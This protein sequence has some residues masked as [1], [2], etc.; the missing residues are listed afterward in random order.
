MGAKVFLSCSFGGHE[1]E[2]RTFFVGLL[3]DVG[4]EVLWAI[5]EDDP[6]ILGKVFPKIEESDAVIGIFTRRHKIEGSDSW[7]SPSSVTYELAF[8]HRAGKG[9]YGFVEEGVHRDE[10]GLIKFLGL[11]FPT[12]DR[13]RLSKFAH[14]AKTYARS[15][16]ELKA[17]R[18]EMSYEYIRY[19][20]DVTV[21]HNGYGIARTR[22][23]LR[24]ISDELR[25][26]PHS[27]SLGG[28]ARKGTFL[29]DLKKLMKGSARLRWDGSPFLAF[30]LV[31]V[32]QEGITAEVAGRKRTSRKEIASTSILPS[33]LREA[34]PLRTNGPLVFQL[35]LRQ[36]HPIWRR[37]DVR[38]I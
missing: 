5:P 10:L 3:E 28:S 13:A 18:A 30:R 4:Y 6:T 7:T 2:V 17:V 20:K 15:W 1:E 26:I 27:F 31:E 24:C 32:P 36:G 19:V 12:F 35:C 22:C 8:A 23:T 29:P 21:Y 34:P 16:S 38:K 25:D 37:V 9:I 11:N 14:E 33:R